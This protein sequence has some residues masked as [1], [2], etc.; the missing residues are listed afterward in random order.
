MAKDNRRRHHGR[1]RPG[2]ADGAQPYWM[3]GRHAVLAA[4]GNPNRTILRILADEGAAAA[5]D[6]ALS[7]RDQRAAPA[8]RAAEAGTGAAKLPADAV[9]QGLAAQ[10]APLPVPDPARLAAPGTATLVALDQVTDPRNFGAILRSCAV[11]GAAGVVVPRDRSAL[12]TGAGAKSASG[13][14]EV[15]PVYRVTNLARTLERLK[16]DG[17]FVLGLEAGGGDTIAAHTP[18]KRG[19]LV[20]GAEGKGLRP[21]VRRHCDVLVSLPVSEPARHAGIDSLNV[22]TAVA[23]ALHELVGPR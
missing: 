9:H 16:G 6:S 22:A 21:L 15:V 14:L 11:L 12:E 7:G 5:V 3:W 20:A 8:P 19:V 4:I 1:R 23:V 17:Y 10:V 18:V 2:S 13:A